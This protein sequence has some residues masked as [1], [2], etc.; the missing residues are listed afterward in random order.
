MNNNNTANQTK[1]KESIGA[2][3]RNKSQNGSEYFSGHFIIDG[4]RKE[5]VLFENTYK[6]AGE[7]TP[8]LRMFLSEKKDQGESQAAAPSPRKAKPAS[9]EV[10]SL[11]EEEIPF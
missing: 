4:E 6:Q 9:V 3:W 10:E 2:F 5:V 7:K 8:D 1:K 11:S